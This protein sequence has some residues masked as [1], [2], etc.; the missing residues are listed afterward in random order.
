MTEAG[1]WPDTACGDALRKVIAARRR[2]ARQLRLAVI[3]LVA[4]IPCA[5]AT[6]RKPSAL[7]VWNAST[8]TPRGLYRVYPKE[9]PRR[10]DDVVAQ[11]P[12]RFRSL[13]AERHYLPAAVPLVKRVAAI[14]GDCICAHGGIVRLNGHIAAVQKEFDA[15][16]RPMP[17]WSGCIRLRDGEYFLLGEHP[18]S[19]DGRYFG[20]TETSEIIGRAELLW[21]A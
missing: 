1:V 4:A 5:L 21:R 16:G 14:A 7:L 9:L 6:I 10:G 15:S 2:R 8:S 18:W 11:L 3:S 17:R 20:V 13:A 12:P 19:F